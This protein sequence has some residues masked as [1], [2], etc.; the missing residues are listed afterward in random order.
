MTKELTKYEEYALLQKQI[1]EL[2]AK[3]ELLR[4]DIEAILPEEGY[5]DETINVFW[6]N[7]KKWTYTDKVTETEKSLK[8]TIGALKALEEENG[9]AKAEEIKQLTIKVK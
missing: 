2:D 1:D 3:K 7:K 4:A 9:D 5:K 6:T 8:E